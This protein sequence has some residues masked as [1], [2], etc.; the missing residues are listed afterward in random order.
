MLIACT[1]ALGAC[2]RDVG[3]PPPSRPGTPTPIA[4][5]PREW[6]ENSLS[7]RV[8]FAVNDADFV[9]VSYRIAGGALVSTPWRPARAGEDTIIVLGLRADRDYEY[10]VDATANGVNRSSV[11]STFRTLPL[12]EVL[13]N[14]QMVN[15]AGAP[16]QYSITGVGGY[17]LA[18]DA[19]GNIVWYHSFASH[20]LPVWVARQENGN[21]T[22]FLGT[23]TGWQP[24]L[25]YFIEFTPEGKEIARYDAPAGYY[26][27]DHELLITGAGASKRAHFFTYSIRTLDL[28]SIGGR[29][30]VETAA[31][32][33]IRSDVAGNV[34]FT[35]DAWDHITPDEWVGDAAA[36]A[37]RTSTD[38]DHPNA[39]T[40]DPAGN[41]VVSWRN[42]NQIMAIDSRTGAVLWRLGG[43]KGEF[44][45]V[46]DPLGGFSKQHAVKIL[47]NGNVL[48][49]DNGSDHNPPQSRAVEYRLDHAAKTA[50]MV[51]ESRHDPMFHAMYIG[52]VDRL[53]NGNTFIGYTFFG[54]VVE[55]LPNGTIGWEGQL[56]ANGVD[57]SA[58][59]IIPVST[60]Y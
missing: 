38:Y 51:W 42:M 34:E 43:K 21:F 17:A 47:P 4:A 25:G 46:D 33:V 8:V 10:Q 11:T 3:T 19:T 48:L 5:V 45:F 29:A 32:Q 1:A 53:S 44:T 60:L 18:F 13:R 31:H 24:V 52:W 39:V 54:R 58:Y 35:W 50:T 20:E 26:M 12:P 36:R 59:R 6:P 7:A 14:I 9:R 28:T 15:I 30:S 55:A 22:A 37:A 27:D 16:S 56:R 23:S 40:F 2:G 49:L 57:V 41:Y